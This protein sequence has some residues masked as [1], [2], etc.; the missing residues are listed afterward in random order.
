MTGSSSPSSSSSTS[1]GTRQTA[2]VRVPA[3]AGAGHSSTLP[4][5][6]STMTCVGQSESVSGQHGSSRSMSLRVVMASG[7]LDP[8][9]RT[10]R[11]AST[12]GLRTTSLWS[13]DTA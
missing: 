11:N 7:S 8:D 1:S 5:C 10:L 12:A 2:Q 9:Q 6:A 13:A 3:S 4:V